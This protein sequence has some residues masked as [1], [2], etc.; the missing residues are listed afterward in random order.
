MAA[1]DLTLVNNVKNQ[2]D[3]D[4]KEDIAIVNH[5][6]F[7]E[8]HAVVHTDIENANTKYLFKRKR[9]TATSYVPEKQ[10][11]NIIG[12]I[13]PR[14][15]KVHPVFNFIPDNVQNY[16]EKEPL[17]MAGVSSEGPLQ[18]PHT[19][20]C[21]RQIATSFGE[22]IYGALFFAKHDTAKKTTWDAYDGW[23]KHILDDITAGT[24]SVANKN[25]IAMS[26]I[27]AATSVADQIANF[28]NVV[29]AYNQLD[30][31]LRRIQTLLCYC[32]VETHRLICE[33]YLLKYQSLQKETVY[34]PEFRFVGLKNV[35][36][37]PLD[38]MGS[39]DILI[40]TEPDNFE[41]G[42]DLTSSGE[43]NS[44][45]IDIE[46]N[47]N[48]ANIIRYQI[49]LACG[50]RVLD[51]L[52]RAFAITTG[53]L[54]PTPFEDED[55]SAYAVTISASS[56]DGGSG[57]G[58]GGGETTYTYTPVGSEALAEAGANPKT[59]GWYESDGNGGYVLTNDETVT[60][61][62]AYYIR[63]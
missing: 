42:A 16:R 5:E 14:E 62:K 22:D 52:S 36:F 29:T 21:L 10:V 24:I 60:A 15:L 41:Y 58:G 9:G 57:E 1:I 4:L 56:D 51:V 2:I 59:N 8:M 39:G 53:T 54:T 48:D 30:P 40:F 35:Q 43:A 26:P 32:T 23:L 7:A 20:F 37:V 19:E 6:V 27:A 34:N 25:L 55:V 46:K 63:S 45:F 18:A 31:R 49:Q 44:A 33:G 28:D 3:R 13:V 50:T 61:Q 38:I 11:E 12:K 17:S 47:Y